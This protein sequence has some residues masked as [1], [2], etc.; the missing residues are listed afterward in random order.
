MHK[1]LGRYGLDI[2]G[3]PKLAELLKRLCKI[4]E[5][6]WIRFLYT[7]PE[8][9]TKELVETVKNEDKICKY[10]D[11][12]IQHISNKVLK[13]MNRKSDKRSIENLVKKIR[14]EIPEVILRTTLITGFPGETEEDFKEL[15]NFVENAKFDKL[16]VFAYS[17]EDRNSCCK[18]KKAITPY[19]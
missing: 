8:T 13:K 10:F 9:I 16:G 5:F 14:Q 19:D 18:T 7:Y 17:K 12:P 4:D 1:T 3:E 6:K 15:Y 11:I 2:Y